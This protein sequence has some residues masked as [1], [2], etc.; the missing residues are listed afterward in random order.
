MTTKETQ[1]SNYF[2]VIV[3]MLILAMAVYIWQNGY[4]LG[5]WLHGILN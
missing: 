2:K 3:P 1:K 4:K 5:Q